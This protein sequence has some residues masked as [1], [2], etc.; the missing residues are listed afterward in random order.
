MALTLSGLSSWPTFLLEANGGGAALPPPIFMAIKDDNY[1]VWQLSIFAAFY[2][3]S[4][5][6]PVALKQGKVNFAGSELSSGSPT[7]AGLTQNLFGVLQRLELSAL[8]AP[9][10]VSDGHIP[11][12]LLGCGCHIP[13]S[14]LCVPWLY[15]SLCNY[16]YLWCALCS[17]NG[18]HV[19][20]TKDDYDATFDLCFKNTKVTSGK[21]FMSFSKPF[22]PYGSI[23]EVSTKPHSLH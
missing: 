19:A 20:M 14:P 18:Q 3:F 5:R 6:Y 1:P 10:L 13:P 15:L 11:T 16:S 21:A 7:A 17:L 2:N 4:F 22:F 23:V 9:P 8:L 12:C